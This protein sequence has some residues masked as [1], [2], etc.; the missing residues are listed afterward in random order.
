MSNI[1]TILDV[2]PGGVNKTPLVCQTISETFT[3]G[4]TVLEYFTCDIQ[5]G[6]YGMPLIFWLSWERQF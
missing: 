1:D 3:S 2:D 4:K 5:F 6:T